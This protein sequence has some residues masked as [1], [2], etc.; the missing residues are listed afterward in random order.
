MVLTT[1]SGRQVWTAE[2]ELRQMALS[3]WGQGFAFLP[4]VVDGV[5][6][7]VRFIKGQK[8]LLCDKCPAG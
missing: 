4:L 1:T 3:P 5:E 2:A 6:D 7:T 8:Q